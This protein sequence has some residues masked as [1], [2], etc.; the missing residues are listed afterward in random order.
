MDT[1]TMRD[2]LDGA[3]LLDSSNSMSESEE[4]QEKNVEE[5]QEAME[6]STPIA[7]VLEAPVPPQMKS[8][9]TDDAPVL[10]KKTSGPTYPLGLK[11]EQ[12]E[13]LIAGVAG[14]IG[15]SDPIQNKLIDMF[16]QMLSES[17]KLSMFGSA[18]I[19]LVIAV[20]FFFGRRFIM[21]SL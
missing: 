1:V 3:V 18:V 11:K 16:P 8:F 13:A 9:T 7:D 19:L 21:K 5:P 14:V 20:I 12:L 15:F 4:T 17:G 6:F 10:S 2:E